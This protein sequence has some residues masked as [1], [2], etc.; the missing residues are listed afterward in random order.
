MHSLWRFRPP[1]IQEQADRRS[2]WVL[3]CCIPPSSLANVVTL[4]TFIWKYRRSATSWHLADGSKEALFVSHM[5]EARRTPRFNGD[6]V[7]G[8]GSNIML[9]LLASA[10]LYQDAQ[11]LTLTWENAG[12]GHIQYAFLKAVWVS[13]IFLLRYWPKHSGI[14][15]YYGHTDLS[16]DQIPSAN[17]WILCGVSVSRCQATIIFPSLWI[18]FPFV[19]RD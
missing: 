19:K 16:K 2:T 9:S 10:W 5:S 14:A 12:K 18:L 13:R 17:L 1:L 15:I 7:Q 8:P 4:Q 11:S 3:G 6:R